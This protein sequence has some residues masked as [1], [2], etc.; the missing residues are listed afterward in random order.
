M[1][2]NILLVAVLVCLPLLAGARTAPMDCT[3]GP[4]IKSFGG[5]K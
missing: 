5:S 2:L 4:V 1:R 3:S